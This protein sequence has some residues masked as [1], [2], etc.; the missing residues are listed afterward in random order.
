VLKA[1]ELD[2][3]HPRHPR[4]PRHPP[5]PTSRLLVFSSSR[6]LLLSLP[7]FSKIDGSK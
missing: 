2:L 3:S 5:G 7:T 1:F 6:L 4:H